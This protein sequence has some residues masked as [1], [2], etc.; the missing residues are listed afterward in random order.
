MST[1]NVNPT[2]T[3]QFYN[4]TQD[5]E[6]EPATTVVK[7]IGF[8]KQVYKVYSYDTSNILCSIESVLEIK[9][10]YPNDEDRWKAAD[11]DREVQD[12]YLEW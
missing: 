1:E 6:S 5:E 10:M 12:E 7:W 8:P 2:T 4:A 9:L 3:P 11:T